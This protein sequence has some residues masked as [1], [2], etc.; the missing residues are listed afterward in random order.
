MYFYHLRWWLTTM[1]K[2]QKLWWKRILFKNRSDAYVS[3]FQTWI[4]V[5]WRI[6][7]RNIP[8]QTTSLTRALTSSCNTRLIFLRQSRKCQG[9]WKCRQVLRRRM[10]DK[11]SV[12]LYFRKCRTYPQNQLDH[13]QY[14]LHK[15]N[16]CTI[17]PNANASPSHGYYFSYVLIWMEVYLSSVPITPTSMDF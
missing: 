3:P 2:D 13:G 15:L 5:C 7:L 9:Y 1:S 11:T 6:N 10:I 8:A 14:V 16:V 4:I 17:R 12:P